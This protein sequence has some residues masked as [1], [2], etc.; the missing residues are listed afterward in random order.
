[1]T[2]ST[3]LI[4]RHCVRCHVAIQS[5]N[6]PRCGRLTVTGRLPGK[7]PRHAKGDDYVM[8]DYRVAAERPSSARNRR[9]RIEFSGKGDE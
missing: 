8:E 9:T 1:M 2:R 4:N 5:L 6:C 7:P 3:A